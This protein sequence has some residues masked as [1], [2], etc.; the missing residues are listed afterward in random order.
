MMVPSLL[1]Q[2]GMAFYLSYVRIAREV[3]DLDN[4]AVEAYC[5]VILSTRIL[6]DTSVRKVSSLKAIVQLERFALKMYSFPVSLI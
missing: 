4:R 1:R 3:E 6:K 2:R 5:S